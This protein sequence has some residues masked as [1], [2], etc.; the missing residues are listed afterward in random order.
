MGLYFSYALN[1]YPRPTPDLL[2][3]AVSAAGDVSAL[4]TFSECAESH[5][6][7]HVP[8]MIRV[9]LRFLEINVLR[10]R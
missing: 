1:A 3:T 9:T 4:A 2:A 8:P 7:P 5:L 10:R 6:D